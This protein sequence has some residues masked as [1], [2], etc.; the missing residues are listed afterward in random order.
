MQ[1]YQNTKICR[2]DEMMLHTKKKIIPKW[3]EI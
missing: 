1:E 2:V 3:T